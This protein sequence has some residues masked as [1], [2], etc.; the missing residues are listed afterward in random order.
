M[1]IQKSVLN[2]LAMTNAI[3]FDFVENYK[4]KME[5]CGYPQIDFLSRDNK[6]KSELNH[7]SIF[8]KQK[9]WFEGRLSEVLE[10]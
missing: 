5:Q 3:L 8:E 10:I 4:E 9:L 1:K 7:K 2:S 6:I